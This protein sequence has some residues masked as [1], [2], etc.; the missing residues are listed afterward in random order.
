MKSMFQLILLFF[1]IQQSAAQNS[2]SG[3]VVD[4]KDGS[5]ISWVDVM[6]YEREVL[7]KAVIAN[8]DGNYLIED[9]KDG[10]YTLKTH[11]LGYQTYELYFEL[12]GNLKREIDIKLVTDTNELNEVVIT[13]KKT[14]IEHK[15]DRKIINLGDDI[16]ATSTS[17]G[18]ILRELPSVRVSESGIVS[19]RGNQNTIILVNGKKS[20]LSNDKLISQLP[21]ENIKKI[22]IITNPSAK[23]QA[24]GLSGILN[25][26]TK[27]NRKKGGNINFSAGI[28]TG[29]FTRANGNMGVNYGTEKMRASLDYSYRE[30]YS[31]HI[32]TQGGERQGKTFASN[33]GNYSKYKTP[34]SFKAG[35]D[36]FIDSTNTL[37]LSAVS[38]KN[39]YIYRNITNSTETDINTLGTTKVFTDARN[40]DVGT[41]L[42]FN[43]NYRKEFDGS[44]HYIEADANYSTSPSYY[45]SDRTTKVPST[46]D[47]L[48]KDV[49][50]NDSGVSTFSLDYYKS[51]GNSILELGSRFE[52]KDL[53]D[54][55]QSTINTIPPTDNNIDYK[56]KDA[57]YAGYTVYER[58]L[59]DFS[60]KGGLRV[61]HTALSFK[62]PTDEFDKNYTDL[63]P[64]A[65][66]S[67]KNNG[68][69][70]SLNYSRRIS[71]PNVWAL[72]STAT[73]S[74]NYSQFKGNP[75]IK[76]E[77]ANKVEFN[78]HKKFSKF[79]I[80]PSI[81]YLFVNDVIG[82]ISAID[83]DFVV[84]SMDNIGKS[85]DY[86][87][88]LDM[89]LDILKWWNSNL[90]ASY[91][92]TNYKTTT[93][94][95]SKTFRQFYR[96]NNTFKI[97]K[98]MRIQ[99]NLFFSP[100]RKGL[101]KTYYARHNLNLA[102][103]K[104]LLGKK[105][106]LILRLN[107]AFSSHRHGY[108]GEINGFSV[109]NYAYSPTSRH[110]YLTFKYNF[111]FGKETIKDRNRKSREY[112]KK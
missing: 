50:F 59:G 53:N 95:N 2:I 84:N 71:R 98:D 57:I 64:S 83:G 66:L 26:I 48:E 35:L 99:A 25:I 77:Y 103:S 14:T 7:I 78:Y 104:D 109:R 24:E 1:F 4:T 92:F 108:H 55:T 58:N 40:D 74:D 76:P 107:D 3:K 81:F 33:G 52:F 12:D 38:S 10:S 6:V 88:E 82:H 51:S 106:K 60:I 31:D 20:S 44:S 21:S 23:Y 62:S 19:L 30:G 37:S 101:Q 85:R 49:F 86:G 96:S 80:S 32:L 47:R 68:Y 69:G 110:L 45:I 87:L 8:D 79:S 90:S 54:K 94:L 61:E 9:L 5:S 16:L 15:A 63:F 91:Y 56:Y 105:G 17:V 29:K 100:K 13:A 28:G 112:T 75:N 11:Y 43:I 41:N 72:R 34:Y 65:S 22:E 46:S 39:E 111:G 73:Q 97:N 93:F 102:I 18:D 70:F 89:N 42:D 36:F 27:K 67:Y